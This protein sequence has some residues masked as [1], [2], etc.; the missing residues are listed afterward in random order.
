MAGGMRSQASRLAKA[1][2]HAHL[3]DPTCEASVNEDDRGCVPGVSGYREQT[4][5]KLCPDLVR[6]WREAVDAK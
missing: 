4:L 3:N 2:G 1:A 5:G 6:F